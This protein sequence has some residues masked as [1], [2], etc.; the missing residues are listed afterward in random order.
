[1]RELAD[2][3]RSRHCCFVLV[4]LGSFLF[5]SFLD[6]HAWF[7]LFSYFVYCALFFLFVFCLSC[8]WLELCLQPIRGGLAR[9]LTVPHSP[10]GLLFV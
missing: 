4:D 8:L 10:K 3:L 6:A 1:V 2:G 9:S 5:F 7:V